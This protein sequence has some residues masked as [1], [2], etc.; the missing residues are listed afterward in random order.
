MSTKTDYL[1]LFPN[2]SIARCDEVPRGCIEIQEPLVPEVTAAV[3]EDQTDAVLAAS[4]E[5]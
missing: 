5:K 1:V 4:R 2:G 3:V